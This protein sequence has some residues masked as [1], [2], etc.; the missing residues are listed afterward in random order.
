[1]QTA[2]TMHCTSLF[3][4]SPYSMHLVGSAVVGHDV[5]LQPDDDWEY[6]KSL[7]TRWLRLAEIVICLYD[8][9]IRLYGN[10]KYSTNQ[11][12]LIKPKRQLAWY[13]CNPKL[14]FVCI[15]V[16]T[17]GLKACSRLWPSSSIKKLRKMYS[18]WESGVD[19][20]STKTPVIV[21]QGHKISSHH[22][23]AKNTNQ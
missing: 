7:C 23:L 10:L 17:I 3:C 21:S 5:V 2:P 4:I 6:E 22:R 14:Q 11:L 18:L 19:C 13:I 20:V 16:P 9:A 1:M 8:R 12:N 15:S